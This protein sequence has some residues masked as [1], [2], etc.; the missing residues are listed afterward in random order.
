MSH[1]VVSIDANDNL[2]DMA[3]CLRIDKEH[4]CPTTSMGFSTRLTSL[5]LEERA[6]AM[7][8]SQPHMLP[9]LKNGVILGVL[10]RTEV[11]QALRPI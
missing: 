4:L 5:S 6:K 7:K 2:V 3:E 8:V 10:T 1:D 11:M 9:V